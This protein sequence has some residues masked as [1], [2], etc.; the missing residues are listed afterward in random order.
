[1]DPGTRNALVVTVVAI[2]ALGVAAAT[3]STT[4]QPESD[5]S[6]SGGGGLGPQ[7]GFPNVDLDSPEQAETSPAPL[8]SRILAALLLLSVIG[9]LIYAIIYRRRAVMAAA[10]GL[11]AILIVWLV[12]QL[13]GDV[14]GSG[15]F[16]IGLGG[17][18]GGLGGGGANQEVT[19]QPVRLLAVVFL[20]GV[21]AVAGVYLFGSRDD[22]ES[23]EE[24]AAAPTE[25]EEMAAV[26]AI[27]GRAADRIEAAADTAAIDNQVY[28]AYREMTD[29]LDIDHGESTTPREFADAAAARG[30][31]AGDVA[32]LTDLFEEVRY[33]GFDPTADREDEATRTLRRIEQRYADE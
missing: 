18:A 19:N 5:G 15:G 22:P 30:M 4:T 6:G 11:L 20:V 26:G 8:F 3:L 14:G 1:M 23:P 9:T 33:G 21:A 13:L 32:A 17:G 25:A 24:P 7:P 27:A 16:G 12:M 10:L 31:A 28:R 2:L 29:H